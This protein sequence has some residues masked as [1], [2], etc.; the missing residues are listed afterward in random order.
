MNKT[1]IGIAAASVA[2]V[3]F[4]LHAGPAHAQPA[5]ASQ[6]ITI[7]AGATVIVLP[8]GDAVR[9][10]ADPA[11]VFPIHEFAAIRRMMAE[12]DSLVDMTMPDPG[13]M[14]RSVMQ[15]IPGG[16]AGAPGVTVTMISTGDGSCQQTVRYGAPGPNGQP[17]VHVSQTGNACARLMPTL[18]A[19][20]IQAA[21]AAP[22]TLPAARPAGQPH[23]WTVSN[24]PEAIPT[25][26][27]PRT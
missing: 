5:T 12:M 22:R 18:P 13:Q 10:V 15:G 7:P 24:P 26:T 8:A 9:T 11:V 2:T 17:I 1:S 27:P 3:L 19:G 6:V 21:P 20:A 16:M 14:I 25:G 4:G 23:L